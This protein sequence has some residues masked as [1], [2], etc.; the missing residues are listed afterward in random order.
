MQMPLELVLARPPSD[1]QRSNRGDTG[2]QS[3][4]NPDN[5]DASDVLPR[6]TVW[7]LFRLDVSP[8][9]LDI[10]KR[11]RRLTGYPRSD[12]YL[13]PF[14]VYRD[15]LTALSQGLALWNPSPPR[16]I[17]NNVSIGDVGYLQEGTFIRMFNVM[18]PWDDPSNRTIGLPEP[19]ELLDCAPFTNTRTSNFYQTVYHT[20]HVFA[21]EN[22]GNMQVITP[23]E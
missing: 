9:R 3:T 15:Q 23:D 16:K 20:P 14:N 19:Y 11:I 17:Y 7:R 8:P 6:P 22:D 5:I 2:D 21:E 10:K 1:T 13:M 4:V 18:L 12:T